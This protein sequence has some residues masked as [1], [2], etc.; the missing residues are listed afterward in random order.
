MAARKE[1]AGVR[2]INAF[3]V[4]SNAVLKQIPNDVKDL[5]AAAKARRS[6]RLNNWREGCKTAQERNHL[7]VM[8]IET[9]QRKLRD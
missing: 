5:D 8:K 4:E 9:L 7:S 3:K 6:R 2:R 1:F